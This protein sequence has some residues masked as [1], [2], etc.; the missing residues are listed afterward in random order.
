VTYV[1]ATACDR[2]YARAALNL[3][4]SVRRNSNIFDAVYLYDVGLTR[5]QV[6]IF[7]SIR[8]VS[9][10]AVPDFVP[11]A[12]RCWTWKPWVWCNTPGD[13]V[14]FL[15]AGAE[16]LGSLIEVRE[17]IANHGYFVVGQ[18][19]ALESG[20]TVE[21][22][23]PSDF[24]DTFAIPPALSAKPVIAG[25][26]VGFRKDSDFYEHVVR[27]VLRYAEAGYTL[28][29]SKHE[30]WRNRWVNRMPN[31]PVRDCS[32]F[33][34]DQTLLNIF[35]YKY[36]RSPVISPFEKFGAFQRNGSRGQV[37]WTPRLRGKGEYVRAVDYKTLGRVRN[38]L[39]PALI[40]LATAPSLVLEAVRATADET[41]ARLRRVHASP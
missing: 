17:E 34:H 16:V 11:H 1:L 14:L 22:V 40:R 30:L 27:D 31:P 20:H 39:N 5:L 41:R 26:V 38:T 13:Q 10:I 7:K 18:F 35:F 28:G 2:R 4:G 12:R 24:Y 6:E 25:G 33:R 23:V 8:G 15:D 37:I 32:Y 9:V 21:D 36:I 3:L 29:F 19:E